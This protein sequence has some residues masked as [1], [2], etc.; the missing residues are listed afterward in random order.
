DVDSVRAQRAAVEQVAGL[1]LMSK[2]LRGWIETASRQ[3]GC[4]P[5]SANQVRRRL[6]AWFR[7]QLRE[8]VGLMSPPVENFGEQLREVGRVAATLTPRL[9]AE[10]RRIVAELGAQQRNE[11]TEAE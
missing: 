3:A 7:A 5:P 11:L 6:G 2:E 1:P 10:T 8:Q 9:E 4:E